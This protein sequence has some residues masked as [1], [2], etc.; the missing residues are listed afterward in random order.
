MKII[1]KTQS[2]FIAEI[3]ETEIAKISGFASVY[4]DGFRRSPG[5]GDTYD[6]SSIF[7]DARI[8]LTTHKEAADCAKKLAI[9]GQ[10]FASYFAQTTIAKGG[11]K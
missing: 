11:A 1:G 5:I 3:D 7:S 9:C 4:D 10:K 8:L 6:A 2:G